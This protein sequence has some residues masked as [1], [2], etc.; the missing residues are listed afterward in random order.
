M[1]FCQCLHKSEATIGKCVPR[2]SDN[3]KIMQNLRDA[4]LKRV[5]VGEQR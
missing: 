4:A 1:I 5:E 3:I 2:I